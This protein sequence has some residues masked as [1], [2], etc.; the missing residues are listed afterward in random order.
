MQGRSTGGPDVR[1]RASPALAVAA[2]FAAAVS[3]DYRADLEAL[4][5]ELQHVAPPPDCK[6]CAIF[7]LTFGR[8]TSSCECASPAAPRVDP[9]RVVTERSGSVWRGDTAPRPCA[10]ICLAS[11]PLYA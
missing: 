10:V 4:L 11:P 9:V 5:S 6:Q 7:T 3:D 8:A 1:L 2:K